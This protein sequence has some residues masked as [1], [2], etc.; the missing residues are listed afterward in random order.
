MNT[1]NKISDLRYHRFLSGL[2][3]RELACLVNRSQVWI[4][5]AEH[6][7]GARVTRWDAEQLSEALGVPVPLLFAEMAEEEE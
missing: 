3:Q 7:K 5:R 1:E 2:T 6:G 4:S